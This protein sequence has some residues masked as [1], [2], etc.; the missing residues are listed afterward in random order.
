MADWR[1]FLL[2]GQLKQYKGVEVLVEAMRLVWE[3]RAETRL[4][5]A[6]EG[7]AAWLVPEDPRISL[8]PR[9]MPE[10]EVEPC[11]P[12]RH[13]WCFQYT[14]GQPALRRCHG[15]RPWRSGGGE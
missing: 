15:D 11:L 2:V 14:S 9:Y 7:Q 3:R 13:C 12:T 4:V 5:V 6:G 1:Y 10:L 8:I